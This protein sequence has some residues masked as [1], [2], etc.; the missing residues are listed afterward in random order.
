[1]TCSTVLTEELRS[2]SCECNY[3]IN[4]VFDIFT[5]V[6]G[7]LEK[8]RIDLWIVSPQ[9]LSQIVCRA[10]TN[11]AMFRGFVYSAC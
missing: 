9:R 4:R 5:T 7:R 8:L 11:L 3:L 6:D 1:M 10:T 2:S